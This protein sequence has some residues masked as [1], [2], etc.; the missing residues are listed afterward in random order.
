MQKENIEFDGEAITLIARKADGSM[1]DSLSLLDQ[2]IAYS[3]TRIESN[4]VMAS[5]G[6]IKDELYLNILE[7]FLEET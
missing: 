2:V 6:I 5:L 1:R 4:R 7:I 3:G